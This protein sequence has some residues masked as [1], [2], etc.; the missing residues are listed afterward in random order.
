MNFF[1][2][3]F[4][5]YQDAQVATLD[6]NHLPP[7]DLFTTDETPVQPED[8]QPMERRLTELDLLLKKDFQPEGFVDGRELHDFTAMETK[9][10]SI[11]TKFRSALRL[12]IEDV[13]KSLDEIGP[14]LN[15]KL[16][17]AIPERYA[18]L[19]ARF[20]TLSLK[21]AA[22]NAEFELAQKKEGLCEHAMISYR[23]GFERGFNLWSDETHFKL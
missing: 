10:Q 7:Q 11:A 15:D 16:K 9:M 8:A 23:M 13:D 2:R 17:E 21:K 19:N 5:K 20:N 12:E 6:E 22:L 3:L 14:Y 4:G 18:K 1:Q